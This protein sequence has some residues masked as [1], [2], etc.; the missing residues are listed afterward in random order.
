[1]ASEIFT[2]FPEA[3]ILAQFK[4][5]IWK[6]DKQICGFY[7]GALEWAVYNDK[8]KINIE[9]GINYGKYEIFPSAYHE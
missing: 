8:L 1:M 5:I 7:F 2:I 9:V 6:K 4:G 3:N